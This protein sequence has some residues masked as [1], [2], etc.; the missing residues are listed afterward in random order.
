MYALRK[1]KDCVNIEKYDICISCSLFKMVHSYRDFSKYANKFMKWYKAI[2]KRA[3]VRMYIDSSVTKEESFINIFNKNLSK[4]EIFVY[5]FPDFLT[6]DKIHHE[7]TF[8]SIVRLLALY[9]YEKHI[10]Y[11]WISDVDMYPNMFS[12]RYID[13]MERKNALISYA[14]DACYQRAWIE[15]DNL[16]PII[17]KRL[18]VCTRVNLDSK[19]FFDYL[20]NVLNNKYENIRDV[21]NASSKNK[22]PEKVF[23]YGFDELFANGVL[24]SQ[25]KNYTK[26]IDLK[27][28]LKSIAVK[29]KA[30]NLKR[31]EALET[32]VLF[33]KKYSP[34]IFNQLRTEYDKVYHRVKHTNSS[35]CIK[36]YQKYSNKLNYYEYEFSSQVYIK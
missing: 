28:S 12:E 15:Q 17:L 30:T 5:E 25:M 24:L 19:Y 16:Y 22:K 34:E 32:E 1:I 2:P 7:G 26:L 29:N 6:K 4:L 3:Y 27:L 18:I 33:N 21:I 14:S 13:D 8:G 36:L 23:P 9:N 11:I 35:H 10:K 20:Y 31:I